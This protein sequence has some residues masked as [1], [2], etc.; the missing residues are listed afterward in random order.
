MYNQVA[1]GAVRLHSRIYHLHLTSEICCILSTTLVMK[2]KMIHS[3]LRISNQRVKWPR[4]VRY[5]VST[6][7]QQQDKRC[8][9]KK[10][11]PDSCPQPILL[12]IGNTFKIP[13]SASQWRLPSF[14]RGFNHQ[15]IHSRGFTSQV[16][17]V[18]WNLKNTSGSAHSIPLNHGIYFETYRMGK[19]E[20]RM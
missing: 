9:S 13:K 17:L 19:R 7:C 4:W 18:Y 15:N 14:A 2:S 6:K 16:F 3:K 11:I 10:G 20:H 1:T 12:E 8:F 5:V